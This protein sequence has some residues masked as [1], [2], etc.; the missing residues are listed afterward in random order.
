MG[1]AG[2]T[3]RSTTTL[4]H[5]G[6]RA[7]GGRSPKLPPSSLAQL[8]DIVDRQR[9]RTDAQPVVESDADAKKGPTL[10]ALT[11]VAHDAVCSFGG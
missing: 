2:A 8:I 9:A 4:E 3:A 11:L 10:T 1:T 6:A 7:P 5:S